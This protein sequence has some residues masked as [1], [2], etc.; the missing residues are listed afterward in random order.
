MHDRRKMAQQMTNLVVSGIVITFA[1]IIVMVV[2]VQI[3]FM[4]MMIIV[5]DER[6]DG[7]LVMTV[8]HLPRE[9]GRHERADKHG[10]Q[11]TQDGC[12][13]S[14]HRLVILAHSCHLDSALHTDD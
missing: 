12:G 9:A 5:I 8:D 10:K 1:I 4:V 3:M 11:H 6:C 2:M 14:F 7:G 13:V